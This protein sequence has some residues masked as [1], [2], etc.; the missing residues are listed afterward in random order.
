[1]DGA[2]KE[3]SRHGRRVVGLVLVLCD[4]LLVCCCQVAF[5]VVN[6]IFSCRC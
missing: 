1:M 6:D 4:V 2:Y 3:V 5:F